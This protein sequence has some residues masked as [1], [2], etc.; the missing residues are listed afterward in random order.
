MTDNDSNGNNPR[1][2]DVIAIDI[3]DEPNSVESYIRSRET[4]SNLETH[5]GQLKFPNFI[6][7]IKRK[8]NPK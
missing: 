3:E 5:G 4:K 8:A 2:S 1:S 7:P 6:L